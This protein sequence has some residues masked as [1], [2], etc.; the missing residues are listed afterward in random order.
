VSIDHAGPFQIVA[1]EA[2]EDS[3]ELLFLPEATA[4]DWATIF[5]YAQVREITAGL[6]LVQAGE[7]D[8]ALYL[9]IDGT[10]GVR[11]PR[12]E[13]AFKSIDAPSVVGE[14]AFFDGAPRSATLDALTDVQVVRIDM[15]CF[16]ELSAAEPALAEAMLMDLAR[17]LALRLRMASDVIA[18]LRA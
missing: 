13:T 1:E 3:A 15:D 5:S 14:L 16:H 2:R 7:D 11:M 12:E 4:A 17:I 8:R 6:A 10:L 18:S 9:L